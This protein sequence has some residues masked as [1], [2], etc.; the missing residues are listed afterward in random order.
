MSDFNTRVN[1]LADSILAKQVAYLEECEEYRKNGHR[2]RYCFHGVNQWVDYDCACGYCEEG[3]LNEY[4]SLDE[5]MTYAVEVVEAEMA[6][7]KAKQD[8]KDKIVELL[9]VGPHKMSYLAASKKY[10]ELM[11][12]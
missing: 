10:D 7:E 6:E 9:M 4:S 2:N 8:Q 3:E 12:Q 5:V 11:S 1:V